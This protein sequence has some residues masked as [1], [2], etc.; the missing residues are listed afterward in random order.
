MYSAIPALGALPSLTNV[1]HLYR[2]YI[3]P[4]AHVRDTDGTDTVIC[5][6]R[7]S[8]SFVRPDNATCGWCL[9]VAH[10]QGR[11]LLH[12]QD[13]ER[14]LGRMR[15][16]T[17][18]VGGKESV[19]RTAARQ[20]VDAESASAYLRHMAERNRDRMPLDQQKAPA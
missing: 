18:R 11:V 17:N 6:G 9:D 7:V 16:F 10:R 13:A 19:V 14:A 15:A 3:K 1:W 8:D 5:G 2:Q 12:G 4:V 20:L